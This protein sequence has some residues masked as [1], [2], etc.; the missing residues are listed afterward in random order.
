M[1]DKVTHHESPFPSNGGKIERLD[2][3]FGVARKEPFEVMQVIDFMSGC[4]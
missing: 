4:V 2:A 3:A 1:H